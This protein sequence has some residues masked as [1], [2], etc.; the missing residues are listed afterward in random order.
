MPIYELMR[1]DERVTLLLL[2]QT[3]GIE[4]CDYQNM[5]RKIAPLQERI[6]VDGIQ[7]WWSRRSVPLSQGKIRRILEE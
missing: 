2:N 6:C 3:G 5:N 1:K 7:R 4:K